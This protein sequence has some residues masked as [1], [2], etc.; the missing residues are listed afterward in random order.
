[1]NGSVQCHWTMSEMHG[2][3]L[4]VV[5]SYHTCAMS[6]ED[7]TLSHAATDPAAVCLKQ[8]SMQEFFPTCLMF[9]YISFTPQIKIKWQ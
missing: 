8:M 4:L 5:L 1:M 9:Y 7:S 6:N 3:W 2:K